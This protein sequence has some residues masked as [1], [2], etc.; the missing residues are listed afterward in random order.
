MGLRVIIADDEPAARERLRQ[1]LSQ[2]QDVEIVAECDDGQSALAAIRRLAPNL[3]FL[4]IRMPELSGLEVVQTLQPEP[5]PV[6]FVSAHDS[7]AME[8]FNI[9]AVDYLLK[10]FDRQRFQRALA[11]GR[12][13]A[14]RRNEAAGLGGVAASENR[15]R[16]EGRDR[17][18]IRSSGKVMLLNL[19]D[20]QWIAGAG[21]YIELHAGKA[22][23][24]LRQTLGGMQEKLPPQFVR[25]SKSHI[26][27]IDCIRELKAKSHG[28]AYVRLADG[29][30]LVVTRS[31]QGELKRKLAL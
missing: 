9:R 6:I 11:L 1:L 3:V 16:A 27:N 14:L 17:L 2:E 26:V 13:A 20:L 24:L 29:T 19:A 12:E 4:D 7:H 22:T 31:H 30:Q 10:P 25:I 28:D 18:A 21:N 8:A 15:G 5:P 23:H